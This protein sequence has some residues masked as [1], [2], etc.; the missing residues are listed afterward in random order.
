MDFKVAGTRAGITG[1]QMDI[2]VP[3][4]TVDIMKEAL[5]QARRG[6]LHI[7]DKMY[8]ALPAANTAISQYAPRIY[9]LQ[10]PTDK[11]RDVIGPGAKVSRGTIEQTGVKIAVEDDD[12]SHVPP[13]E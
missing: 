8:E 5:E 7:L 13:A 11:I 3:N 4:I 1:L 10:I 2:K 6:R 9:T 12:T